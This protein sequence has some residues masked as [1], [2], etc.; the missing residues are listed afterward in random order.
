MSSRLLGPAV[1]A[2]I[3]ALACVNGHRAN[4]ADDAAPPSTAPTATA[5]E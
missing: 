1:L 4:Q 5:A 2:A 3:V